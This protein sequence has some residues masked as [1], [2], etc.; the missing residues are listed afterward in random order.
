MT[1]SEK[2]EREAYEAMLRAKVDAGELTPIEAEIE[3][4]Y[5]FNGPDCR[6]NLGGW[7]GGT[8]CRKHTGTDMRSTTSVRSAATG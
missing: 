7:E 3:W 2:Q 4:D 1:E 6:D 8:Q 5:H